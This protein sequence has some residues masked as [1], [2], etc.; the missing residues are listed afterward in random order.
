M[1]KIKK[2]VPA[3][4]DIEWHIIY[5]IHATD[6]KKPRVLLIGDSIVNGYKDA[7]AAHLKGR[8]NLDFLATSKG[9]H[10]PALF[11]E[12]AFMLDDNYRY[13]VIHFN[14]GLHGFGVSEAVYE[15]GLKKLVRLLKARARGAR[16]IWANSTP[17]RGLDKKGNTAH[18]SLDRKLNPRVIARNRIA[19]AIMRSNRIPVNDL[20]Q[21]VLEH[22]DWRANDQYHFN[23]LGKAAQGQ[24]AAAMI[25]PLIAT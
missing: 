23:D 17:I 19:A 9:V 2:S 7:A 10:D 24:A 14:I 20:Y 6:R 13:A 1:P 25:L 12:I 5:W 8:A 22:D 21:L 11:R 16:L 15:A 18:G 4:E 3:R